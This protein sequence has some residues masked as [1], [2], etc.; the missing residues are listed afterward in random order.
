MVVIISYPKNLVCVLF[1][2]AI[3]T[4]SFNCFYTCT[5]LGLGGNTGAESLVSTLVSAD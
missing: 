3:P 2:I 5:Y 4:S 1:G